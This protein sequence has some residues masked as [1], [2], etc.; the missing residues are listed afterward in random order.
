MCINWNIDFNIIFDAG[1]Q[2]A[3]SLALRVRAG[4]EG[5]V[6]GAH[7]GEGGRRESGGNGQEGRRQFE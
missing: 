4:S 6:R 5:C 7:G 1:S 3:R 2:E